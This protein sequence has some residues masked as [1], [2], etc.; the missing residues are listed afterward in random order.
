MDRSQALSQSY[1]I[2]DIIKGFTRKV[3][4]AHPLPYERRLNRARYEQF[5][6]FYSVR[7]EVGEASLAA[8]LETITRNLET[9][10]ALPLLFSEWRDFAQLVASSEVELDGKLAGR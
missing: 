2:S 9:Q 6:S 10:V 8:I 3:I 1:R 4:A 7:R 5:L